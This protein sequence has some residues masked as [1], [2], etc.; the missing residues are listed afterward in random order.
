[1]QAIKEF[2]RYLEINRIN[3]KFI[4]RKKLRKNNMRLKKLRKN[5]NRSKNNCKNK[6]H[7]KR[8]NGN[9]VYQCL[10]K[11]M[12]IPRIILTQR[13]ISSKTLDFRIRQRWKKMTKGQLSVG[14]RLSR[15]TFR[16]TYPSVRVLFPYRHPKQSQTISYHAEFP[17]R[18]VYSSN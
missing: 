17:I 11:Q 2:F 3:I 6:Y 14:K 5:N 10:L 4:L 15:P 8:T 1:M 18:L 9:L 12:L 7:H 13:T 16:P